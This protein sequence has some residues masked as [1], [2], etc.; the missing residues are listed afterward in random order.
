MISNLEN[1]KNIKFLIVAA[2]KYPPF[3]SDVAILF[4]Q[5]MINR[6]HTIDW[7]LQSE[8]PCSNNYI[9]TWKNGRVFVGKKKYESSRITRLLKHIHSITHDLKSVKLIFSNNYDIIQV[10]DKFV[11]TL[12]IIPFA[13][14]KKIKFI[15]WLSYPYPEASLY[16]VK[17][18]YAR[19]PFYYW[20]RG[21]ILKILLYK[22]IMPASDHI[23]V[24]SDQMKEDVVAMG[25]Y[26]GKITSVPMGVEDSILKNIKNLNSNSEIKLKTVIYIGTMAKVRKIDFLIKVFRQVIDTQNNVRFLMIGDSENPNDLDYLKNYARQLEV[27]QHITFTGNLKREEALEQVAQADICV[28]PF[29]PTPI[30]NSTSPTK[31]IEYMAMGKPVVANDHPEQKKVIQESK[32]GICVPY[33]VKAFSDAIIE[34]ILKPEVC[35][36]M[37]IA[38]REY[39]IKKRTYKSI[40]NSVED[41]YKNLFK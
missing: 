23:F 24:Q 33:D 4:G 18:G 25:I 19:Y 34:L 12:F 41:T 13:K 14:L 10:K 7:I 3:R 20:V 8:E 21:H 11:S 17:E 16:A 35:K 28:S 5:E 1:K 15:Y 30:L 31:L 6:G 27:S 40:A 38:G 36:K 32:A 9:T 39:V 29:F 26:Q 22:Y 37:G 2:D